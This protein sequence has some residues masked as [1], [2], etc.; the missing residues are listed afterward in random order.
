[1]EQ[2][3]QYPESLERTALLGRAPA[4]SIPSRTE[5]LAYATPLL[6]EKRPSAPAEN[7]RLTNQ[8]PTSSAWARKAKPSFYHE[9]LGVP[10]PNLFPNRG[11]AQH[12]NNYA[13]PEGASLGQPAQGFKEEGKQALGLTDSGLHRPETDRRDAL[14]PF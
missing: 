11:G 9:G 4:T 8:R 1:M 5:G 14:P 13:Q 3:A 2:F 12:P 7:Q 10:L 6:A